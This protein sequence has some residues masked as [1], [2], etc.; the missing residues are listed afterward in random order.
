MPAAN[1]FSFYF[2]IVRNE[3]G[4]CKDYYWAHYYCTNSSGKQNTKTQLT[5]TQL[6]N[7]TDCPVLRAWSKPLEETSG[8]RPAT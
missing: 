8:S 3:K 1:L 6:H 4:F 7:K 2:N 5:M